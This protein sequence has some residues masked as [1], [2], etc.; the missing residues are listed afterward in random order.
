MIAVYDWSGFGFEMSTQ[1]EDFDGVLRFD[2]GTAGQSANTGEICAAFSGYGEQ[3]RLQ[4]SLAGGKLVY[5]II[6]NETRD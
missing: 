3:T 5:I 4:F 6:E 1:S 2:S